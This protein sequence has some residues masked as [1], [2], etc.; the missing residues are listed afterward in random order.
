MYLP[1]MCPQN[2]LKLFKNSCH[3]SCI[4]LINKFKKKKKKPI[5]SYPFISFIRVNRQ[6]HELFL[7]LWMQLFI[8]DE[9][10]L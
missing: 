7:I 1:K 3:P 10:G 9:L 8:L 2:N 6:V 4:N 5:D